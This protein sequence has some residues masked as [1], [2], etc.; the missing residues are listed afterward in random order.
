MKITVKNIRGLAKLSSKPLNILDELKLGDKITLEE[1]SS[2]T[3]NNTQ[4][5]FIITEPEFTINECLFD[6]IFE[7][8]R[9]FFD[10]REDFI[11]SIIEANPNLAQE[12]NRKKTSIPKDIKVMSKQ[13]ILNINKTLNE[14]AAT[15]NDSIFQEAIKIAKEGSLKQSKLKNTWY[16]SNDDSN[17]LNKQEIDKI[18]QEEKIQEI[19]TMLTQNQTSSPKTYTIHSDIPD[20]IDEIQEMFDTK[21]LNFSEEEIIQAANKLSACRESGIDL[22]SFDEPIVKIKE[23]K[24]KEEPQ[25]EIKTKIPTQAPTYEEK[26]HQK[27]SSDEIKQMLG[28]FYYD[29]KREETAQ[30]ICNFKALNMSEDELIQAARSLTFENTIKD[31]EKPKQTIT[32]TTTKTTIQTTPKYNK[33]KQDVSSQDIRNMLGEFSNQAFNIQETDTDFLNIE[34]DEII[35]FAKK[36]TKINTDGSSTQTKSMFLADLKKKEPEE[37]KEKI[38]TKEEVLSQ[39]KD[40]IL[41]TINEKLKLEKSTEQSN[42]NQPQTNANQ[43]DTTQTHN[44]TTEQKQGSSI[45]ITKAIKNTIVSNGMKLQAP[46]ISFDFANRQDWVN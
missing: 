28:D 30:N 43:A 16:L 13:E 7:I 1:N 27:V 6:D 40:Q 25:E 18:A 33:P 20:N 19:S 29:A 4:R 37:K 32:Q 31:I 35:D 2:I 9:Y 42:Q 26:R 46:P 41:D 12:H 23:E 14:T 11:N 45:D 36:L 15:L 39:P 22:R 5:D 17:M 8:N 10:A 3:I 38:L 34:E 44:Q 24:T 21:K